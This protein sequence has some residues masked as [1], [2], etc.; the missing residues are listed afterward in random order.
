M[1][2]LP[3]PLTDDFQSPAVL[4]TPTDH[5]R[6]PLLAVVLALLAAAHASAEI[7]FQD[8]FTQPAGNLSN[9]VPWIDAEG[10]GW[11][12]GAVAVSQLALDGQGHLY[13]SAPNAAAAAGIP[14]IPIG[15][16][17]SMT[18]SALMQLPVGWTESID[19]GFANSNRFLTVAT[20]GSGP[21]IQVSGTGTINL[22]GGAG[23]TNIASVPNAF[24]NTGNP[25][26]VFLTYDAFHATASV[27]TV[28][29]GV[30]N[31]VFD[32]WPLTNSLNSIQAKYLLL[33]FSTN[34]TTP[35]ARWLTAATVDWLPRPPPLLTLPAPILT[36]VPVGSP[37]ANDI[38]LIQNALNQAASATNA[39]QVVF[40]SG[41]TYVLTNSS[42]TGG[43]AVTL[44][45][46]TNVL[47]NG[48][49]CKILITNPRIGFL[50]VSL[51]SNVIVQGF[52]VDYKPL[53]FTQGI[54]TKNYYFGTNG[55]Q[56]SAIEFMVDAGYPSPTNANY[57]DANAKRWGT[58]MDPTRPGRCAD[59]SLTICIYT[60]VVQT[61]VNGAYKVYLPFQAQ[62]QSLN[63]GAIWCMISRWNGS[64]VFNGSRSWQVTFLNNTN[65]TGAGASYTTTYCP[66]VSEVNCQV[67]IGPTPAGATT[68]RR[69]TSNADGGL[70]VES[71]IGPWVQ[72]C[73]FTGMSDDVANA[74]VNPFVLLSAPPQP[75]NTFGVGDYNSA[76][77][78]GT[79]APQQI[80]VDDTVLFFT[81]DNGQV[82][83]HATVTAVNLPNVTFDHTI[84]GIAGSNYD[85]STLL[86][87][88]SLNTSAVYLNNQF[89]NSRIHGIYCRA[90]NML[91][92]HNNISGMGLSAISAFPALGLATP[93]SFLPTNVVIMDNVL[94]DCSFSREAISNSI[95]TQEPAFAL[96]ELHKTA[97]GTDYI[98]PGFEISG[99]RIL[100]NAFLDWRRAPLS[101]HNATDV[102]VIGNY[103]G[104]PLTNDGYVPLTNDVIA[105]LWVC[106]YPN[107]RFTNNVNATTLPNSV[108]INEDGTPAVI[109][110]AFQLPT[111]PRL[112]I[113][114]ASNYVAV[115][116]ISPSPGY[117]LQQA[118]R[119]AGPV[120][121]DTTVPPS[122]AGASNI[123][124]LPLSPS[125]NVFFRTRQR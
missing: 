48:N 47:V 71:R 30:T 124:T 68:P 106:D 60:N 49:G 116:W 10:F 20:S 6:W 79:L 11:Q 89:S 121:S 54:V 61:N 35:T 38:Q 50:S 86:F 119:V 65:Y 114:L 34:L 7:I 59:N 33:Q 44:S 74:C 76:G 36:T 88:T 9:S 52:T 82:F 2:P 98:F 51:C 27:G 70:M 1:R 83:D 97:N 16:H 29:A 100:Y 125:T 113:S 91:I 41:A 84:P 31:H 37:G 24:T 3:V 90:D 122:L 19:M 56:E 103:F 102:N 13:N 92:A 57:L 108:A 32:Q 42:L 18:V 28:N 8:F 58:V 118:N 99:I 87:N 17:G 40:T 53:P 75:T 72:N 107:L 111:A 63:P 105:D 80:Q 77:P 25:V 4:A 104:P 120:W 112:A 66:L 93:N 101:L 46:A 12:S 95:P 21:W 64:M 123:V 110:N 62:V 109:P 115:S 22:Y 73:N 67:Q 117:I 26:Q 55:P 69:R 45:H 43:L 94:S 96:V 15:P 85:G 39:S 23:Q 14:L 5:R 81:A 78:P